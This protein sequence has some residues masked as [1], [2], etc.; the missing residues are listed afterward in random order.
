M[1]YEPLQAVVPEHQL[2]IPVFHCYSP[3]LRRRQAGYGLRGSLLN[4]LGRQIRVDAPCKS[5]SKL[6]DP[7][8]HILLNSTLEAQ[9]L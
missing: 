6:D 3:I 1:A 2:Q 7:R 8:T 9:S 4:D 5:S